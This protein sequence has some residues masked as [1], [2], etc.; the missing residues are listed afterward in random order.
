MGPLNAL[1]GNLSALTLVRMA[2][3]TLPACLPACRHG[4]ASVRG[5]RSQNASSREDAHRLPPTLPLLL[6][7]MDLSGN[8]LSGSV[9]SAWTMGSTPS[10]GS[11][12]ILT[13]L[14]LDNNKL[15]GPLPALNLP[16]LFNATLHSN[17]LTGEQA[18]EAYTHCCPSL[19]SCHQLGSVRQ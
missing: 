10:S 1:L 15:A 6:L 11:A 3:A 14:L 8:Q 18:L 9:P 2:G 13:T 7:Q 16:A 5:K 17:Q 19:L 4:R 12:A